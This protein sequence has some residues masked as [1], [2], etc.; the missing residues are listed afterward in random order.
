MHAFIDCLYIKVVM[1][2]TKHNKRVLHEQNNNNCY[3][4]LCRIMFIAEA[5][6]ERL[7]GVDRMYILYLLFLKETRL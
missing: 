1:T 7:L 5:R 3:R 4:R 2:V 6:S